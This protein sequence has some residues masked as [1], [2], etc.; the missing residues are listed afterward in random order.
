[1]STSLYISC[2]SRTSLSVC[3]QSILVPS[4]SLV[5]IKVA[6][7]LGNPFILLLYLISLSLSLSLSYMYMTTILYN[8]WFMLE[9][10]TTYM[11]LKEKIQKLRDSA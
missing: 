6:Y 1:M 3:D 8:V 2:F 7:L 11:V 4:P 5:V 10:R 9:V